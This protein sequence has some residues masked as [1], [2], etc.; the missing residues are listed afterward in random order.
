MGG[1]RIYQKKEKPNKSTKENQL[2]FE[3]TQISPSI[4]TKKLVLFP[5]SSFH[6]SKQPQKTQTHTNL[7][8]KLYKILYVRFL[9]LCKLDCL[10]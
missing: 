10:T 7:K 3:E 4:Q 9:D 2:N 5:L 6:F 8:F 1:F